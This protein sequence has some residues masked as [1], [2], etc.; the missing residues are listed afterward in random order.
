MA[1]ELAIDNAIQA[2]TNQNEI[3][4]SDLAF[5]LSTQ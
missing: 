5:L 3:I 2:Q 4:F 1:L